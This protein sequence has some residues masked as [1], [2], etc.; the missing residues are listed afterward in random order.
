MLNGIEESKLSKTRH[1]RVQPIPG[2]KI[3]DIKENLNDLLHEE[4]QKVIIHVGA[5]NAMTDTPKEIF[6]KLI[7]LKHQIESVMPKCEVSISN[8]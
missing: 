1:I 3:D 2:G 8:F 4:L 5:N 7:S 6:S